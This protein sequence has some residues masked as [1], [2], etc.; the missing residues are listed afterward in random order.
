MDRRRFLSLAGAAALPGCGAVSEST[1]SDGTPG[2]T[3]PPT[4][5]A[6]ASASPKRGTATPTRTATPTYAGYETTEVLV[7]TPDGERLGAVTAAIAD[8]DAL[9]YRGLSDTDSLPEDRGMLFVF[10]RSARR[11][12]VTRGMAFGIDIVY[13]APDG[14]I[15]RIHHAP[16]PAPG[17]DGSERRYP[18]TGRYVLEVTL[19]WTTDRGV[20]EG[21]LLEFGL[22]DGTEE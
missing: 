22:P 21:D 3:A 6:T 19:H 9:R 10:G 16:E 11:T 13:A 14:R 12:F 18:G 8:T 2:E 20:T 7:R 15:T 1:D 4:R 17:E 5:G